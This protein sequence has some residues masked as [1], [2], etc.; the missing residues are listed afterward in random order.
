MT[1]DER[2]ALIDAALAKPKS[3]SIDGVSRENHSLAEVQD[4]GARDA[5]NTAV[6]RN[7]RGIRFSR[8]TPG[9]TL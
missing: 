7:H 8:M 5:T 1:D 4:A 6:T 3:I 9:G 2:Q